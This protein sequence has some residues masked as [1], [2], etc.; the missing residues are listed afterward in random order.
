MLDSQDHHLH[1]YV[2]P[3]VPH[4]PRQASKPKTANQA[5]L[6]T[7]RLFKGCCPQSGS[8]VI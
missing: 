5:I 8:L 6:S 7:A 4:N 3:S 1:I 2:V